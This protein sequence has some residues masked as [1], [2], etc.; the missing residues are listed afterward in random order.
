MKCEKAHQGTMKGK[1]S[2]LYCTAQNS[3]SNQ[4]ES[5]QHFAHFANV[6]LPAE[7][8]PV[9]VGLSWNLWHTLATLQ[10]NCKAVR[11]SLQFGSILSL[12]LPTSNLALPKLYSASMKL[13]CSSDLA[14]R[15]WIKRN[16]CGREESDLRVHYIESLVPSACNLV[17]VNSQSVMVASVP[18]K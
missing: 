15:A 10:C 13:G 3:H 12:A 2:E 11:E 14:L 17:P 16:N 4:W 5:A 1:M 7:D 6:D 18:S 9:D 8:E